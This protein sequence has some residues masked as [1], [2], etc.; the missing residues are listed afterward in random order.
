MCNFLNF[1][2]AY[3]SKYDNKRKQVKINDD[4]NAHLIS[5]K[6]HRYIVYSYDDDFLVKIS[7]KILE[8]LMISLIQ[9]RNINA[10]S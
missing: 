9:K 2:G 6:V 1:T 5:N 3:F 10:L 7:N 4:E 8:L